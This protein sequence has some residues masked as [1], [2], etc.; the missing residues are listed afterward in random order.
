M[1]TRLRLEAGSSW[2]VLL[3]LAEE[4]SRSSTKLAMVL[5]RLTRAGES[6]FGK[7]WLAIV[8]ESLLTTCLPLKAS[9]TKKGTSSHT[10]FFLD[11]RQNVRA[12]LEY[13]PQCLG[14]ELLGRHGG[15][16]DRQDTKFGSVE[17]AEGWNL[18]C[19]VFAVDIA[20]IFPKALFLVVV[21]Q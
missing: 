15:Q 7:V 21:G 12:V 2:V 9:R 3:V 18:S 11:A 17:V 14:V 4:E 1:S 5:K 20:K 16:G 19:R 8:F 6:L 10:G 13:K